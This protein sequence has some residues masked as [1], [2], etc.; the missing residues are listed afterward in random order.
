MIKQS[1]S[2]EVELSKLKNKT[3]VPLRIITIDGYQ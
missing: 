3:N 1:P 2:A